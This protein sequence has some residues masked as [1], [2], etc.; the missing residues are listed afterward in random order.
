MS[1]RVRLLFNFAIL[2]ALL[3]LFFV[4]KP[5]VLVNT[6]VKSVKDL[7]RVN[8]VSLSGGRMFPCNSMLHIECLEAALAASLEESAG[9]RVNAGKFLCADVG[10][11]MPSG[12]YC[13]SEADP[14]VGGNDFLDS[15]LAMALCAEIKP[16]TSILDLGAGLGHYR[17]PYEACGLHWRGFDGALN[18][19]Q[20]TGGKVRWADLS[21][22]IDVGMSDWVQSLEVGEHLP[23]QYSNTFLDNIVRHA[24]HGILLSWALPGQTGHSHVNER[25]NE[26]VISDMSA[27]NF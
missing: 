24:R 2:G 25:I 26:G 10:T 14:T 1:T 11:V 20:V 19:E 12:A 3:L 21:V 16:F 9:L 6:V 13:V 8:H 18:I 23:A 27:R 15:G 17:A 7:R 22:D 5:P 4:P